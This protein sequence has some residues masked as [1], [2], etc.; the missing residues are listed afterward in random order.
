MKNIEI[1][2]LQDMLYKGRAGNS[3]VFYVYCGEDELPASFFDGKD[4]TCAFATSNN[5]NKKPTCCAANTLSYSWI[6]R[7]GAFVS[8]LPATLIFMCCTD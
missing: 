6:D 5:I 1:I 4:Q 8:S 7:G 2:E 3:T